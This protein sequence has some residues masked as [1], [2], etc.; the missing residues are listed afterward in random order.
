MPFAVYDA[1]KVNTTRKKVD[2][3]GT[4]DCRRQSD[5]NEKASVAKRERTKREIRSLFG[6]VLFDFCVIIDARE[7]L[8]LGSTRITYGVHCD[9]LSLN[10][11]SLVLNS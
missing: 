7:L 10:T 3:V 1:S 2:L 8:D 11:C 4:S 6:N 9:N 5:G